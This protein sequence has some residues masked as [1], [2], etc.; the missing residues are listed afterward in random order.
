[1]N[2][3]VYIEGKAAAP[4]PSSERVSLRM[5]WE[6]SRVLIL[7]LWNVNKF[8]RGKDKPCVSSF[9]TQE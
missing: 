3:G 1:M 8:L 5:Q 9:T 2:L 7:T 6:G 4:H